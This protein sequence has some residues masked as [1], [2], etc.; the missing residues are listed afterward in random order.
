MKKIL[1][2]IFMLTACSICAEETTLVQ[3]TPDTMVIDHRST[4]SQQVDVPEMDDSSLN[5][6]SYIAIGVTT[7]VALMLAYASYMLYRHGACCP[8]S[9]QLPTIQQPMYLTLPEM[10]A[11]LTILVDAMASNGAAPAA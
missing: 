2:S 6:A 5:T 3:N 10:R 1:I 11:P 7:A 9:A 4:G 8:R